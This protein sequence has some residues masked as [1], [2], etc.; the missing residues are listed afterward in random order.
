M[1]A[2]G[3]ILFFCVL[4]AGCGG[5]GGGNSGPGDSTFAIGG[6]IAGLDGTVVLQNNGGDSLSRSANGGFTFATQLADGSGY[7]VSILTQPAGQICT[8]TGGSGTVSGANVTGVTVS[9]V[10]D[11]VPTFTVGGAVTG[12]V[13]TVVLQNS[14]SG[15]L[16]LS[17]NGVFTF[18]NPLP[19]G[20]AYEVT[21]V[22]Q[23]AGQT[24]T[25]ASGSGT[26]SG[27]NVTGV[28]VTCVDDSVP[29]FTIGG[30][31]TGL[32][33]TVVLQNNSSGDLSL[34]SGG[35]FTF[36]DPVADGGAYAVTVLTQPASQTCSVTNGAGTVGGA[37]VTDVAVSC[38]S[39]N[40]SLA[41]L[42]LS[43]GDLDQVFQASQLSYTS[44]QTFPVAVIQVT[45]T[46]EDAGAT[47][48][49]DGDEVTSG[50]PSES[51]TLPEGEETVI[52]IT[53]TAADGITAL[54]YTVAVTRQAGKEFAQQAYVKASNTGADDQFG[55]SV[56]LSGDGDTLAV[57]AIFEDGNATVVDGDGTNN[58]AAESG[59]VYVFP[60]TD[61][62]WS[63]QAYIKASNTGADDQFGT[64]VA[65][66][67]DGDTLAVGAIGEDSNATS[68]DGNQANN[69]A[70]NAGAVYVFTRS[71]GT[72]S[73]QAYVKASNAEANDQFG[74]SVALSGDGDT[75]AVGA[76]GE[77]GNA[78]VVDGDHTNN[79]A[80]NSGAAYVFTRTGGAWTQQAYVKASNTEANDR[81]GISIAL[82]GDG[83][84][85][86]VGADREDSNATVIDGDHTDNSAS[87]S[88]A[89]YVFTRTGGT[90]SQQAYVKASNTGANDQ[91]G[92]SVALSSDG[93]TL[94]VGAIGEAS[95]TT[96]ING[97]GSNNSASLSGAAY[98]FTRLGDV[99][100]QQAYIKASN[101]GSG[102]RFGISV[103]LSE[104]GDMLAVGAY[105]ESSNAIGINGDQVNNAALGSGAAYVFTRTDGTWNQQAYV[106]ASNTA[107]GDQFGYSVAL[108]G[109]G[110]TFAAGART[111]DSNATGI[112]VDED[113]NSASDSGAVYIYGTQ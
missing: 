26:V 77:D 5:G 81:F 93:D 11:S 54:T 7:G 46:A 85:L 3:T 13:G 43:S 76:P 27:A 4:L 63:Q 67:G 72:W 37:D 2:L 30:T 66:S 83:D 12:L 39:A 56:A 33:G 48:T 40:A 99:W 79:S 65:L 70:S 31:I 109:T 8:V 113:D 102:D 68:I 25:I 98:V 29:T 107:A 17:A 10:D 52:T 38:V 84:T 61:G 69:S 57:G 44:T 95:N 111:E 88:G 91:F 34:S 15:N 108:S 36:T 47:I 105:F 92:I 106:K 75:L 55:W 35:A 64:S 6:T 87:N 97:D 45:A 103:A 94:A 90:W 100:S 28:T 14:G 16:S 74:N 62:N 1:R 24:C 49:V 101:T 32:D 80:S 50:Q 60:R 19:D 59:A 23:P 42:T 18:A 89:A 86:A 112:N 53:V 82:S 78:T 41:S 71:G 110:D 20:S 73:Q 9:C 22:T 21:V 96:D 51:I 58:S 104:D